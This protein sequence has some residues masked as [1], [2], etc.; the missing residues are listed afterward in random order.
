MLAS[1]HHDLIETSRSC[2]AVDGSELREIGSGTDD[3][4][5]FHA[6]PERK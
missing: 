1:V 2:R 6:P 5:Q 3:V 4:E